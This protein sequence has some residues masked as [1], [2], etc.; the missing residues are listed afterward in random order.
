MKHRELGKGALSSLTFVSLPCALA[1][2]PNHQSFFPCFSAP[3]AYNQFIVARERIR[4]LVKGVVQG[5]G[6]RPFIYQLAHKHGL[7]GFVLNTGE[8]VEIE[9]EGEL[10]DLEVFR[11]AIKHSAPPRATIDSISPR[12]MH[13]QGDDSFIIKP[14][15]AKPD[16]FQLVSPDI[17]TC[18]ECAGELSDP[19]DRRFRY[20]FI[21]CTNCGPRFTII[22]DMPYDRPKTTMSKFI[23]CPDCQ[24]EYDDPNNRR[25]HAQPN[26]CPVCGPK[27]TFVAGGTPHPT[28]SPSGRGIEGE[29]EQALE[30]AVAMLKEGKIV[31]VKG[32]GGFQLA[33]DAENEN[34]VNRLRTRKRRYGKPLAVMMAGLEEV[35]EFCEMR[36]KERELLTSPERPIVLLRQKPKNTL[37]SGV[38]PNNNYLG[39]MLPYTPLHHLLMSETGLVL[40]MTSGNLS[41]EPIAAENEEGF[42]RLA[43]IADGYLLHNRDIYSRYDDSVVRVVDR[44]PVVVRRARGLAPYPVHLMF[45]SKKDI[46][47]VG[48]ELK[49]TFCLLKDAYAF[50]S[51]HLGDLENMETFEHF[52]NTLEL[53][54]RLF[55]V[56][57]GIVACDMHPDYFS[58]KFAKEIK[59]K[60]LIEVQHHH[61]HIVSCMAENH[62]RDKVIGV[63]FDGTGYGTDGTIWGGEF[64]IADW[65]GYS[66]AAHLRPFRL[67]GGDVAVEKPYRTAFSYLY[68]IYGDD[69]SKLGLPFNKRLDPVETEIM[70][71]QVD[72]GLLSPMTSSAGRFFD[73]VSAL[74]GVRDEIEFEGQAA[75]DLEMQSDEGRH[76]VY[77][78]ALPY[79]DLLVID[80]EPVIRGIVDDLKA[81]VP[82]AVI[83]AKFHDT[84]AKLIIDVCAALKERTGINM[85]ALSGGVFQNATLY[86]KV[87]AG[88]HAKG[89]KVLLPKQLPVNDGGISL[90]QAVVAHELAADDFT[91]S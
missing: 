42:R 43:H 5:V 28:L 91:R 87:I 48:G 81:G 59:A 55:R 6:F 47:A 78:F 40:V 82:A 44:H 10:K 18:D 74:I 57:P 37:A 32:L 2:F 52:E 68:T 60:T 80:T 71:K 3:I 51:Q 1:L 61:A 16:E 15:L 54:E 13:C 7:A 79:A 25:F 66:R 75:I 90:G 35:E 46:L 41:E 34:A 62:V 22:E 24:A 45:K 36:A 84:V 53:Y 29:G 77:E 67:P 50:V 89:F 26:A 49:S 19:A 33:C 27:L 73:A 86:H 64:L 88:L 4:L 69:Y 9:V 12:I 38:A 70:K 72:K 31:A 63:A 65:K 30:Q 58:T 14:S 20:P 8:G 85:V 11:Y 83:G 17:A 56:K 21:N 76:G 39:V 23:M